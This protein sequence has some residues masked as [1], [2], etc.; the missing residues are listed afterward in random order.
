MFTSTI[1][2]RGQVC[3]NSEESKGVTKTASVARILKHSA[4]MNTLRIE[5][6]ESIKVAQ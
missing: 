3:L 4:A 6:E 2:G 5:L 1:A